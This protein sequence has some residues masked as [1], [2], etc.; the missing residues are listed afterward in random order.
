[1]LEHLRARNLG[2]IRDAEIDPGPGLTVITGETGAGKTLLLGALRLLLGETSDA[3]VVGPFGDSAQADGLFVDDGELG[4]TR[5]VPGSGRSRSYLDGAVASVEALAGRV[6][7]LV[8]VVGQHDQLELKKPKHILGMLDSNL[9]GEGRELRD[10]YHLAWR[11][12]QERLEE[13]AKLGGSDTELARELDLLQHQHREIT[14]AGFAPGDD[15]GLEQKEKRLR[16]AAEIRE[17]LAAA[18]TAATTIDDAS[19]ELVSRL[20]KIESLDSGADVLAATAESLAITATDL[21]RDLAGS[22]DDLVDDPAA[23]SEIEER[24]NLLGNLKR[25][26]GKTV[27]EVLAF[28]KE[29][30]ERAIEVEVLLARASSI[31]AEVEDA[32]AVVEEQARALSAARR[33]IADRISEEMVAHLREVGLDAATVTFHFDD[34]EPGPSGADRVEI[35]FASHAGLQP[36]PL[37]KVASGGELSRLILAISLSTSMSAESTLVFDEVDTGIGGATALA[38]GRKLA[39]LAMGR[40][41]L[42]VTHLPQVAA[43]ADTH[44]VITRSGSEASVARVSGP[45]RLEELSRMIAGLPESER[46][47]QAAVELLELSGK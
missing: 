12:L 23:L 8:E 7:S 40:Q 14:E 30:G 39:D 11:T 44:Y 33:T 28:G 31:G 29:A 16:N 32:R 4:I 6:G 15:V 36:G 9:D 35:H 27:D 25:K 46:G 22:V 18:I 10:S 41:V 47:Q 3:S 38:M 34:A 43:F 37:T 42:C 45:G 21:N 26:Y 13:A 1:M 24:L 17:H 5:I 20:R 2:L 19:G